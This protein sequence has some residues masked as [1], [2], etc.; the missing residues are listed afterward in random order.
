MAAHFIIDKKLR[1]VRTVGTGVLTFE[2]VDAHQKQLLGDPSFDPTFNQLIDLTAVSVVELSTEEIR[3]CA[4]HRMFSTR[5]KRALVATDPGIFGITR[6]VEAYIEMSEVPS[7]TRSFY[8]F[9][10]ALTWLGLDR[11]AE[12]A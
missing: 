10:S 4:M 7:H 11:L 2:D 3:T 5:S 6:M 1:L 8:D 12:A 9:P